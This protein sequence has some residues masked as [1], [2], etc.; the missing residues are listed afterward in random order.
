DPAGIYSKSDFATRD[1]ARQIVAN[2][3][4]QTKRLESEVARTAV[5]LAR[6]ESEEPSNQVLYYLIGE[7]IHALERSVFFRP[8]MQQRTLRTL[9]RH[10]E[11]VYLGSVA[12]LT[13]SF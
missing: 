7:G 2:I 3:A 5:G 4:R 8:S 12:L 10:G 1:R 13:A 11:V 9:R 6:A